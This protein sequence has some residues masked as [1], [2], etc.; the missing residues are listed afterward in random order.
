MTLKVRKMVVL[1]VLGAVLLLSNAMLIARWL[2]VTGAI[3][4][5]SHIRSEYLTGTAITVII[6]MLVLLMPADA[7][8]HIRRCRVCHRLLFSQARYCGT[9]GSRVT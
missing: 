9:C 2:D 4:W 6:A 5:A 1:A 7:G 8:I 3:G